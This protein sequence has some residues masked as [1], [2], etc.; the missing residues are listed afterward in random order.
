MITIQILYK[1]RL[2]VFQCCKLIKV[3][4]EANKEIMRKVSPLLILFNVFVDDDTRK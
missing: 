4:D 3:D 2:E 1:V